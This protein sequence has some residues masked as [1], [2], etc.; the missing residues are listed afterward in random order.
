MKAQKRQELFKAFLEKNKVL[1]VD[2]SSASRRRLAKTLIDM[3]CK[4]NQIFSVAH[5]S[6]ALETIK[7]EKPKLVLSDFNVQGG[8]G[9]DLFKEYRQM[10]KELSDTTLIL[11]TS[12]ISQSAVAKAA[13]EDVDSFIIKPYTVQSLEK[14][15]VTAVINKLY[16]SKYM[17]KIDEGKKLLLEGD[18]EKA[19]EVFDEAMKLTE[20]PSLALFYHGQAKYFLDQVDEAKAD[21]K[22]GLEV[23]KIH[24]K[25]Q[26]GLFELFKKEKKYAE[27]YSVVKN[28]AKYF[29]ANPER[30]KEVV[31]LA[32]VTENYDDLEMF[33]ETF[34][35]LEERPADV[36]NYMCSGLYVLGRFRFFNGHK[37]QAKDIFDKICISCMGDPKFL[38]AMIIKYVEEKMFPEAQEVL[39]RYPTDTG[40]QT[41]YMVSTYLANSS[42]MSID[43][44]VSSG[45]ELF[46]NGHR[47]PL[48]AE[49]LIQ[50]L[51]KSGSKKADQYLEEALHDWPEK[52]KDK[53]FSKVA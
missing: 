7:T 5:Y 47:H 44:L 45:L 41:G 11:I 20:Q 37:S 23:N 2:K 42:D 32:V 30:L 19:L 24:F 50:A 12:N 33:Y 25:C 14:S 18:Y 27:A 22:K 46:N 39:R 4:R 3:G 13:E 34:T 6:E 29:P 1:I 10:E 15:L 52:F 38:K 51:Y 17:K 31:R 21:Y 28:I 8:S 48:A 26:V 9:F 40:D 49:I 16:P 53:D 43:E 36:V 35:E